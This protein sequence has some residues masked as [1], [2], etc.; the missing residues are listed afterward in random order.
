MARPTISKVLGDRI[1]AQRVS[2]GRDSLGRPVI[3]D[4]IAWVTLTDDQVKRDDVVTGELEKISVATSGF[5]EKAEGASYDFDPL[6]SSS[7]Q[8]MAIN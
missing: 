1:G 5:I 4:Y 2:A 3:T 7:A 8:A 6:L